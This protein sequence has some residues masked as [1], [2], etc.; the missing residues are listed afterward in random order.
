MKA[1]FYCSIIQTSLSAWGR[2]PSAYQSFKDSNM[3]RLPSTRLLQYYK[4]AVKQEAGDYNPDL[5]AWMRKSALEAKIPPHGYCGVISVDA[6]SI[7]VLFSFIY[8]II[9]SIIII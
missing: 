2:S 9:Y 5:F 1:S 7:Q 8:D 3:V 4:N 6:M